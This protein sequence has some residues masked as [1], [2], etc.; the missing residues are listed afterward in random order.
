MAQ[1]KYNGA[2]KH[3]VRSTAM[4]IITVFHVLAKR[5]VGNPT[6]KAWSINFEIGVLFWRHQYTHALAMPD[7]RIGRAYLDSLITLTDEKFAVSSHPTGSDEPR[8]DWHRYN[9]ETDFT[10]LYFHGG[11]YSLYP[12]T[13]IGFGQMQADYLKADVFMPDYRLLPENPHPAQLEDGMAAYK[14]LLSQN[15]DAQKLVIIGESG[16]GH[17]TLKLLLE[18]RDNN[19][20]QPALAVCLCPWTGIGE[21]KAS[22]T[23]NDRY[24]ILQSYMTDQFTKPLPGEAPSTIVEI[25]PIELNY[26]NVAPIYLQA[27]GS[28]IMVD[29]I[30]EFADII[31]AQGAEMALDVWPDMVHVFQMY[32]RDVADS[33]EAFEFIQQAIE[34]KLNGNANIPTNSRTE[35]SSTKA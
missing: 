14:Y 34:I 6:H 31:Q 2:M 17:L 25:P 35:I 20:P 21:N 26:K 3:R 18:I 32:G 30:R 1:I 10:I 12:Q 11:G 7:I 15:I 13:A 19:L 8:G 24:D 28:E 5:L 9:G 4:L 33:E 27:G 16:G 22:L 29:F 23:K